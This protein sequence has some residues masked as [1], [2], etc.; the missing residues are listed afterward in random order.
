MNFA[1]VVIMKFQ[2]ISITTKML[3]QVTGLILILVTKA[4]K[5]N[6]DAKR[7]YDDLLSNYNR[8]DA[9]FAT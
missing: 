7:L 8:Y 6:P 4:T 1:Y 2:H 3:V 9:F 5:A